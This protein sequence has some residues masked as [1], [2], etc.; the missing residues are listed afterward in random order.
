MKTKY[1]ILPTCGDQGK[2]IQMIPGIRSKVIS[3]KGAEAIKEPIE[4]L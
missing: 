2:W 4:L 3:G 1:S